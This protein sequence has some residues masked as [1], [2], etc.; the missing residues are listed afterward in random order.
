[1][2]GG[3]ACDCPERKKPVRERNWVVRDWRCN[4]SAFSGYKWTPS[5]YSAVECLKCGKW[6]RTKA[7]YVDLLEKRPYG[8]GNEQGT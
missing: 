3:D 7:K 2:S 1:M 6:W 8:R 5:D 4:H